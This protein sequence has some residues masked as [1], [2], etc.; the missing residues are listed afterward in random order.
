MIAGQVIYEEVR[1][2]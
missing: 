2:I 1:N